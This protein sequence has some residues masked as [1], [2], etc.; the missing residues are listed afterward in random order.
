MTKLFGNL[1]PSE[2]WLKNHR[3]IFDIVNG[4]FRINYITK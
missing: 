4:E 1:I 3:V 2:M